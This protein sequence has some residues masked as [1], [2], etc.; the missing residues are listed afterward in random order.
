MQNANSQTNIFLLLINI[1]YNVSLSLLDLKECNNSIK[2][3]NPI[4]NKTMLKNIN[5]YGYTNFFIKVGLN[6]TIGSCIII[7][8]DIPFGAKAITITKIIPV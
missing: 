1:Q 3:V 6:L 8:P 5:E 2:Q 4:V 7:N